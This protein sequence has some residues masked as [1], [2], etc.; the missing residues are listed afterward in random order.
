MKIHALRLLVVTLTLAAAP[1]HAG[2]AFAP[3]E[4]LVRLF[5]PEDIDTIND[6]FDTEVIDVIEGESTFRL[7]LPMLADEEV[8][9][10][11]LEADPLTEWAELNLAVATMHGTT[12]SFF[13][14]GLSEDY[15]TQYAPDRMR[16]VI[17]VV[18]RPVRVAVLDTGVD[19]AHPAL[20][21]RV[22]DGG[23]DY[24]DNDDDPSDTGNGTDDDGDGGVDELVGHG[25]FIAGLVALMSA[26]AEVLPL[27]VLNGDGVGYVFQGAKALHDAIDA[28]VDIANL[29]F[30]TT[31]DTRILGRAAARAAESGVTVIA[32]AGNEDVDDPVHYP[33][34]YA[35]TVAVA[36]TNAD[37]V[38]TDFSNFGAH[39]TLSCPGLTIAGPLP[40]EAYGIADGT[41][42]SAG[43][44]SGAVASI[45][46]RSDAVSPG[47]AV[48]ALILTATDIDPLNP[49][50]EGLLGA[51]RPD[52]RAALDEL[53]L[54]PTGDVNANGVVD[55][56][57]LLIVISAWGPNPGHPADLDGDGVV[58][59]SD[60]LLV[61]GNWS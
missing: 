36:A 5:S 19:A 20:A 57:D 34:G 61:L 4:V 54:V 51:G 59:M 53:G 11:L 27:R 18:E 14:N 30:S 1:V 40:D 17:G 15:W 49:G 48:S 16:R 58:A 31:I 43:F 46:E 38:K 24:V 2:S 42:F 12:G 7:A 52:V 26:E 35:T 28:G 37:D 33:A 39:I 3:H 32:A 29:S 55:F 9:R 21:G 44:V 47:D 10:G 41:S 56:E 13:V 45:V 23:Y 8:V 50:Y 6:E 60:L 25:T 22:A